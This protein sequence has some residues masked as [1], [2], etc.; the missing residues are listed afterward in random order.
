MDLRKMRAG[1]VGFGE[2]N[3]PRDLIEQKCRDARRALEDRGIELV[4]T[5]PVSDDPERRDEMRAIEELSR[6]DFDLLVVCVAGWIPSHTVIDVVNH[7]SHKPMVLWGLTGH[8]QNG[9][10]VTTADQA[11]TTALRD[12]MEAL[13]FRS[14]THT[15]L[16]WLRLTRWRALLRW[17][18]PL[19]S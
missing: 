2:V 11:G 8:L 10:L 3:S 14:T 1:F 16:R 9:R 12:P 18:G 15:T 7:W 6:E 5:E 13:G 4:T 17:P 19:R